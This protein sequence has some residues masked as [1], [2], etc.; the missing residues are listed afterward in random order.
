APRRRA[1]RPT[2]PRAPPVRRAGRPR[3]PGGLAEDALARVFHEQ[4]LA[5]RPEHGL[6]LAEQQQA[7]GGEGV[8]ERG[9]QPVLHGAIEIDH[10]VAADDE[11]VGR[12]GRRFAREAVPPHP[13]DARSTGCGRRGGGSVKYRRTSSGGVSVN[14]ASGYSAAAVRARLSRSMS[15]ASTA[16]RSSHPPSFRRRAASA[17][18]TAIVYGSSPDAH[19]AD[20]A[21]TRPARAAHTASNRGARA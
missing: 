7:P 19:P 21:R 10:H 4:A 5:G 11:I 18:T 3:S 13:H 6:H 2:P 12:R 1:R 16:A 9:E 17:N 14:A 15:V 8:H 20:Q